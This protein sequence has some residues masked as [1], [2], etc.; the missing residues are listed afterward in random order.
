MPEDDVVLMTRASTGRPALCSSRQYAAA[1]RIGANVPLRCTCMTAHRPDLVDHLARGAGR[2]TR[3][4]HLGTQVVDHDGVPLPGELEGVPPAD[5]P[6]RTRHDDHAL[7]VGLHQAA[8][9]SSVPLE[10]CSR[11]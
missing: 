2:A 1:W 9:F 3:A 8:S 11:I 10:S 6:G 5:P 4:V 7:L